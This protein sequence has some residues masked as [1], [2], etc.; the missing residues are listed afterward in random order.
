MGHIVVPSLTSAQTHLLIKVR[1]TASDAYRQ[2]M[3]VLVLLEEVGRL[4]APGHDSV[5]NAF[6]GHF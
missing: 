6:G 1:G 3:R 4:S 5:T 2:V